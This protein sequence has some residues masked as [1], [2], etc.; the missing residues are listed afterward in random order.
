MSDLLSFEQVVLMPAW[1]TSSNKWC[2]IPAHIQGLGLCS[3]E[4]S[5]SQD[6]VTEKLW[7]AMEAG[8]LP[9][10]YG[11][12]NTPVSGDAAGVCSAYGP[13]KQQYQK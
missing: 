11:P 9:I 13:A 8:C 12:V 7:Q 6:Y 1:C 2:R 4:N 5:A 3:Q 10:Y